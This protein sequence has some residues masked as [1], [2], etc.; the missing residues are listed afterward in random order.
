MIDQ[1][2]EDDSEGVVNREKRGL[3]AGASDFIRSDADMERISEGKGK[4]NENK[5]DRV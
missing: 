1:L 4:T 2:I 3:S 5:M